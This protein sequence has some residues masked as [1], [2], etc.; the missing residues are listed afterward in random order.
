[1]LNDECPERP[2]YLTYLNV[3]NGEY[4]D[5]N[6]IYFEQYFDKLIQLPFVMPV[7]NY[8]IEKIVINSL[9][10][11]NYF[12]SDEKLTRSNIEKITYVIN[13]S[14]SKNPRRIKRLI[15]ALHLSIIYDRGKTNILNNVESKILNLIFVCLQQAYPKL[16]SMLVKKPKYKTWQLNDFP[17]LISN[18]TIND[19]M[20]WDERWKSVI[21]KVCFKNRYLKSR[22]THI[23]NIFEIIN[24][25]GGS[26]DKQYI[27]IKEILALSKL[28]SLGISNDTKLYYDG[29]SYDHS[30]QTQFDQGN[31]LLS[32][33]HLNKDIEIL[34]VGCG[35]GQLTI[36]LYNKEPSVSIDA[37]DLSESQIAIAIKKGVDSNLSIENIN[38]FVADAL[39]Y[40]TKKRYDLIFSNATLHWIVES[41][42]MYQKL[43]ECKPIALYG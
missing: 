17:E 30:S 16:Y 1:M 7:E 42:Q 23:I 19:D 38:F 39:K 4:N 9:Y 20:Q 18:E 6:E 21:S 28:T 40:D 12:T 34:D 32:Q 15:N 37:F 43:C 25:L 41:N 13:A 22:L 26:N 27:V 3:V 29:Y 10:Q 33:I 24:Q 8:H 2:S 35:N 5:V 14:I 11:I 31:N 36:E